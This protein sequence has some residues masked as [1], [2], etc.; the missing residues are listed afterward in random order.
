MIARMLKVIVASDPY[1]TRKID[2][3]CQGKSEVIYHFTAK[4]ETEYTLP[5]FYQISL[6]HSIIG[7]EIRKGDRLILSCIFEN[8]KIK[9]KSAKMED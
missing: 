3:I 1:I 8:N 4:H 7:R 6:P 2:D 9:I 5:R